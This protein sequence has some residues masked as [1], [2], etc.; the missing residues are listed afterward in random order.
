MILYSM[1]FLKDLSIKWWCLDLILREKP[2]VKRLSFLVEWKLLR[3]FTQMPEHLLWKKSRE[4]V[5]HTSVWT[6]HGAV[7]ALP[8]ISKRSHYENHKISF[9]VKGK[10]Q[11]PSHVLSMPIGTYIWR[12]RSFG[13][14]E[15]GIREETLK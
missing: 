14:T 1:P 8:K 6:P 15:I 2:F 7:S 10:N 5:N 3:W 9:Y 12:A 11:T 13:A 4:Y